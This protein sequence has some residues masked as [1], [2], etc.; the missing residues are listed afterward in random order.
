MADLKLPKI[1]TRLA[2]HQKTLPSVKQNITSSELEEMKQYYLDEI[3]ENFQI[4]K[5]KASKEINLDLIIYNCGVCQ[6]DDD[7]ENCQYAK[8][9]LSQQSILIN[10]AKQLKYENSLKVKSKIRTKPTTVQQEAIELKAE[11]QNKSN[12]FNKL[13]ITS[14]FNIKTV[15][16]LEVFKSSSSEFEKFSCLY[17][18]SHKY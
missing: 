1:N 9:M 7:D 3:S 17:D 10:K 8:Y 18:V 6:D 13:S 12:D 11:M 15:K 16:Q 5:M 4:M 14:T 2:Y